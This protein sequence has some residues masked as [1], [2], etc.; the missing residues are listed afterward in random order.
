[1]TRERDRSWAVRVG[2]HGDGGGGGLRAGRSPAVRPRLPSPNERRVVVV[3]QVGQ[4][5][6]AF[7]LRAADR[8]AVA[9]ILRRGER[10]RRR[11]PARPTATGRGAERSRA[12]PL[13][14]GASGVPV[15]V[16]IT[17]RLGLCRACADFR[18]RP[19]AR[20]PGDDGARSRIRP[21][22]AARVPDVRARGPGAVAS[23]AGLPT[24]PLGNGSPR[25]RLGGGAAH[26]VA[27][28]RRY[29][30]STC[31][32]RRGRG[33]ARPPES[34][35]LPD[36]R[37]GAGRGRPGGG[38]ERPRPRPLLGSRPPGDSN[39]GC[40]GPAPLPAIRRAEMAD[41]GG[42][43]VSSSIVPFDFARARRA[44]RAARPLSPARR[45]VGIERL[46][47]TE[48]SR[49]AARRLRR[50]T[51][52]ARTAGSDRAP[53]S[54]SRSARPRDDPGPRPASG[55]RATRAGRG[56]M[57]P[58]RLRSGRPRTADRD[59]AGPVPAGRSGSGRTSGG[60]TSPSPN[61]RGGGSDRSRR[62]LIDWSGRSRSRPRSLDRV[63]VPARGAVPQAEAAP[64]AS[65][66]AEGRAAPGA[67]AGP[68]RSSRPRPRR[69]SRLRS[70]SR[71]AAGLRSRRAG[72]RGRSKYCGSTSET[73]KKPLRPTEKSTKAAWMAG[74]RLTI[75]PL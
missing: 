37:V 59:C 55:F 54:G 3:R 23:R 28:C 65:R 7:T 40:R 56:L 14:R 75:L 57:V 53:N 68:R 17:R 2:A 60:S 62:P 52:P 26:P 41:D 34:A 49:E 21:A 38:D 22:R 44:R 32:T 61:R 30:G 20:A 1:M 73:C 13:D 43:A 69:G 11:T 50:G 39:S 19:G 51:A 63:P 58:D 29:S 9:A 12:R 10:A 31:Q 18:F 5:G 70:R 42:S 36:R 45:K 8:L 71:H 35:I 48:P 16:P 47:R 74:S 24:L 66:R 27:R 72:P 25:V 46:D 64:A 33:P 6:V 4:A 15:S 67:V